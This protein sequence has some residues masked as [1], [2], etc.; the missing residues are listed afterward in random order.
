MD[1]IGT[2]QPLRRERTVLLTSLALLSV[3]S[4]GMLLWQARSMSGSMGLTMG[5]DV[6]LFVAIW[7]VMMAAMM[8]PAAAPMVLMFAQVQAGKRRQG[9]TYTPT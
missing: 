4:W 6:V 1:V 9:Q 2:L 7:V 8:F 5:M 3:G